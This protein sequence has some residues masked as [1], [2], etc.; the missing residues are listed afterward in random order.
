MEVENKVCEGAVLTVKR[1][2]VR[3]MRWNEAFAKGFDL[4]YDQ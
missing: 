1:L 3:E 2:G 4:V